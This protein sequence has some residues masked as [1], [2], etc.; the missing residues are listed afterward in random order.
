MFNYL[1][2]R[3]KSKDLD[4]RV[5][6]MLEAV[7]DH[8]LP[9]CYRSL[10]LYPFSRLL[11]RHGLEVVDEGALPCGHMRVVLDVLCPDI[12]LDRLARA[13]L[14]KHQF[15]KGDHVSLSTPVAFEWLPLAMNAQCPVLGAP[16]DPAW[17]RGSKGRLRAAADLS[18]TCRV[19]HHRLQRVQANA[20]LSQMS[21]D[22]AGQF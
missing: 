8:I 18:G 5:V 1:A 21:V 6:M 7:K 14:V 9:F 19:S 17:I 16:A 15:V 2:A 22:Q 4:R 11:R 10:D 12:A 3:R 20:R 13:A